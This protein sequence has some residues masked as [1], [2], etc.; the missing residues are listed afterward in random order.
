MVETAKVKG[1]MTEQ[2]E[3]NFSYVN[4]SFHLSLHRENNNPGSL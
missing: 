4:K 1:Q 2:L 3:K